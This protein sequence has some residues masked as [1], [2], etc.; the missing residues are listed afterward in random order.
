MGT[1]TRGTWPLALFVLFANPLL[2]QDKD[3]LKMVYAVWKDI[4]GA[5]YSVAQMNKK[6]YDKVEA[7]AVIVKDSTGKVEVTQR[8]NKAGGSDRAIQASQTIDTAIARLSALP[9]NAADSV[10]AYAPRSGPA[11]HLSE[12]DLKKVV[13]M[14][15]PGESALLI[16]SPKPDVS[17]VQKFMGMGG[18]GTPEVVVVDMILDIKE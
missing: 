9:A 12:K 1:Y 6:N 15:G 11:S 5:A 16:I 13:S 18:Q 4:G 8:H 3:P 14:L 7:W 2:A 10:S 17:E